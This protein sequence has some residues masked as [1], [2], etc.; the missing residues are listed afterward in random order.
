M[1][2]YSYGLP[3]RKSYYVKRPWQYVRHQW[4]QLKWFYQRGSRGYA[5]C[6]VW[7]IDAYIVH[8]LP[9][10]LRQLKKENHGHPTS[11]CNEDIDWTTHIDCKGEERWEALLEEMASGL[12]MAF[13]LQDRWISDRDSLEWRKFDRAMQL[14]HKHF[15][16]LWD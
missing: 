6:D 4:S 14:I 5:D 9:A 2:V 13:V 7:S 10:A 11:V 3:Y 12:E 16:E 8:W 15:F 1:S